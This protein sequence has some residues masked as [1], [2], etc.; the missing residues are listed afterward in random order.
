MSFWPSELAEA[1]DPSIRDLPLRI[2]AEKSAELTN[3]LLKDINCR[4][5]FSD[6]GMEEAHIEKAIDIAVHGYAFDLGNHPKSVT[7]EDLSK[8]YKA[9]L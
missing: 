9:C 5:R 7:K 4:V 8:L 1:F 6:F 2:R 3:R